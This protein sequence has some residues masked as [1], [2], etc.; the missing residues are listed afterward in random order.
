LDT[1]SGVGPV[2]KK[3]LMNKYK[4]VANMAKESSE[5]LSEH[6]GIPREL[7][8]QIIALC[9]KFITKEGDL[10]TSGR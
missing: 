2:R 1:I 9:R 10:L 7:A 8:S 5:T 3:K 4:N 6:I